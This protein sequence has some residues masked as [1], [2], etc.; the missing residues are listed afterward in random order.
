MVAKTMASEAVFE[1]GQLEEL[2]RAM[3]VEP[4]TFCLGSK[5]STTELRPL[6]VDV[7][8]ASGTCQ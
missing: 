2:E 8:M 1:A 6:G 5:H 7:N 3:G 4:T